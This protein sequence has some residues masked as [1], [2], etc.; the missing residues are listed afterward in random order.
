MVKFLINN[1]ADITV[2]NEDGKTPLDIAKTQGYYFY[3]RFFQFI[4]LFIVLD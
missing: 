1:N 4:R 3:F 2:K